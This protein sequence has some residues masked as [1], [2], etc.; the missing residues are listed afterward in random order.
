MS[1]KIFSEL[2][3]PDQNECTIFDHTANNQILNP[4]QIQPRSEDEVI[5]RKSKIKE[6]SRRQEII[7]LLT[8]TAATASKASEEE[9]WTKQSFNNFPLSEERRERVV[10]MLTQHLSTEAYGRIRSTNNAAD[11]VSLLWTILKCANLSDSAFMVE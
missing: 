3:C 8:S 9:S 2:R 7:A 1:I 4:F 10:A 5:F 6:F 11:H